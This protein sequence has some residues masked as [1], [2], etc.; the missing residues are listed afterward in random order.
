MI[1]WI[2][3]AALGSFVVYLIYATISLSMEVDDLKESNKTNQE[4]MNSLLS[5]ISLST[6][7]DLEFDDIRSKLGKDY[8]VI[9]D[10]D[11]NR[12]RLAKVAFNA[13]FRSG[14]IEAVEVIDVK[15]I[16]LCRE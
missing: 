12:L 2:S 14:K 13:E 3:W 10:K 16:S 5:F 11:N 15:K 6:R 8:S 9:D 7:C 4:S 1:R